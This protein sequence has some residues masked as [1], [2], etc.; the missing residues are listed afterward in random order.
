M[1]IDLM[2]N[3]SANHAAE[4]VVLAATK[5]QAIE[6][7]CKFFDCVILVAICGGDNDTVD[8]PTLPDALDLKFE[9]RFAEYP[10]EHFARKPARSE[11]GLY[12]GIYLHIDFQFNAN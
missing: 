7:A 2:R 11:S 8:Q 1:N 5:T 10:L 4:H 3:Q 9:H 6:P 12:G